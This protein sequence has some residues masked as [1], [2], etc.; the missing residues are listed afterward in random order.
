MSDLSS[1][2]HTPVD[3]S[4]HDG[5]PHA[6]DTSGN[7]ATLPP[8]SL[9]FVA[10]PIGNL[11]DMSTRAIAT[12]KAADVILCEDTRVTARL[13]KAYN[14]STPTQ[15]LHDHNEQ[16]RLPGL[17]SRL[18]GG[19]RLALV[20][21][22]GTPLV[23]D[24]GFRLARAAISAG[25]LVSAIPGANAATL[26]LTLSGLPP[27]PYLFSG[28][29]SPRSSAR[30]SQFAVLRAAEQAGLSATLI[31]YEAPHR[32]LD[33]LDDL[34]AVFGPE[35]EAAVARELTKKFEE[36][37]RGSLA[38]IR[39]H[40]TETAPRGEITVLVG[41][42]GD[43]ADD[44]AHALDARLIEA[45]KTHSVKDAATLVAGAVNLPKRVVYA[46]ALEI[47]KS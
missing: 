40:F 30:R 31:W 24:P 16:D 36:I 17:L 43:E 46:R 21:D 27:H 28:F 26:A 42:P 35:R 33:M 20:S 25:V 4:T 41:P 32:L 11:G 15:V 39:E 38:V 13:L 7:S 9:T 3:D 2:T 45:L 34:I 10:T 12:L 47:G 18:A 6:Y 19:A 44:N 37:R 14:V 1:Y 8:G 29:A 22:A 23:S 5:P